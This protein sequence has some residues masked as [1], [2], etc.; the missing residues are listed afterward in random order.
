M[1][2]S[3]YFPNVPRVSNGRRSAGLPVYSTS[4]TSSS[5]VQEKLG[6]RNLSPWLISIP[7]SLP[8]IRTRFRVFFL[9]PRRLHQSSVLRFG[10]VKGS[11]ILSLGFLW[12]CFFIFALAKRFGTGEKK[13]PRPFLGDPPT[14]VYGRQDLQHIWQW[15]IA[16]GHYPSRRPS[17][18]MILE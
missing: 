13:W 15:E 3:V 5:A 14:L 18:Q 1:T 6:H 11:V 7:L 17:K 9:N 16:S 8:V 12:F 2:S 10:R 4:S